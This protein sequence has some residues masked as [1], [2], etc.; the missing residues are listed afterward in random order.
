MIQVENLKRKIA[1]KIASARDV[2]SALD[3]YA[4]CWWTIPEYKFIFGAA[5]GGIPGFAVNRSFSGGA[6]VCSL[7]HDER[8]FV[9]DP[10]T[11]QSMKSGAATY[12]VDYSISLDTNAFSYLRPYIVGKMERLRDDFVE[13]FDLI[14]R[15]D[16]RVDGMPYLLEN[17]GSPNLKDEKKAAHVFES[18]KAYEVLRSRP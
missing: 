18:I 1:Y 4:K 2:G 13:V 16:V 3:A 8:V 9:L 12:A 17:L 6:R 14:A 15:D 5:K 10:E 11:L 7:F